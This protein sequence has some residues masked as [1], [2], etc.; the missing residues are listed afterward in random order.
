MCGVDESTAVLS[1]IADDVS[2]QTVDAETSVADVVDRRVQ[3]S[4]SD[5][6]TNLD[7]KANDDPKE[8]ILSN[9]QCASESAIVSEFIGDGIASL[10]AAVAKLNSEVLSLTQQSE[11]KAQLDEIVQAAEIA[12]LDAAV[13]KL[14]SE[15][16]DLVRQSSEEGIGASGGAIPKTRDNSYFD[17]SLY[18]ETSASPPPHPL[19]TYRW[20]DIKREKE[21]VQR[22]LTVNFYLAHTAFSSRHMLVVNK[23]I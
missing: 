19:T 4:G 6:E 13:E 8:R 7:G 12:S 2:A 21:K 5:L 23:V 11:T 16:R 10:D 14:N 20:E 1:T 22:E 17:Y 9:E 18:R 15:V 3:E